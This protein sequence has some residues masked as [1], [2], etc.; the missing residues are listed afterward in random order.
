[1]KFHLLFF[2]LVLTPQLSFAEKQ[3]KPIS[4]AGF[5][6]AIKHWQ[7]Q[8]KTERENYYTPSDIKG[9]ANNLLLFQR[10]SG[11]WPKNKNP[12]RKLSEKEIA[13]TESNKNSG[14]ATLDNRNTYTQIRYLAEAYTQT[15]NKKYSE[16]ASKGLD[17][18]LRNQYSN[19][20]W[21]HSPPR[22]E[23]HYGHITIAD[24]V[25]TGVLALLR[26][27]TT[28]NQH[29]KFLAHTQ[30][31]NCKQALI[32]GEN[33]LIKLQIKSKNGLGAW[34]G[35]YDRNSLQATTGRSYEL[36]A[37]VSWESVEVVRYL[38]S[39]PSPKQQVIDAIESAIGWFEHAKIEGMRL[40]K[41]AAKPVQF[42][43]HVSEYDLRVEKDPEA[44]AI[45]ARFYDIDTGQA[46]FAN[47]DGTKVSS[48]AEVKR[49]RR[50]GYDWYGYW[51]KTLLEQDYPKW[52]QGLLKSNLIDQKENS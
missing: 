29:Y 16:A 36:P 44:P 37:L 19:G 20:G 35:Q 12:L 40:E 27:I 9:I 28:N 51:P 11:G 24:E 43:F 22:T 49:D 48:L 15:K 34:A 47:R 21:A 33:L 7:D 45:W 5:A 25:M 38:M 32:R 30:Q 6:D 13:I 31:K 10:S 17:Y 41:F 14:D 8:N 1:M 52:K 46:I 2:A 23:K 42:E 18:I 26:D 3:Y 50:T 39:I 4:L